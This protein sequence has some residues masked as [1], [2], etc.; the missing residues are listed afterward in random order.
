[1]WSP[2]VGSASAIHAEWGQQCGPRE[3]TNS[4]V[5]CVVFVE[6][7]DHAKAMHGVD[8]SALSTHHGKECDGFCWMASVPGGHAFAFCGAFLQDSQPLQDV[9]SLFLTGAASV[10]AYDEETVQ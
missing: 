6:D 4:S 10:S 3:K 8:D 1:M 2:G 7:D 5:G 9:R